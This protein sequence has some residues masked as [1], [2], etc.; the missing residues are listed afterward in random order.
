MNTLL[1]LCFIIMGSGFAILCWRQISIGTRSLLLGVHCFFLHPIFVAIGWWRLYG[2]PFDPRLWVAFIVHDW[3]YFGKENMDGPEGELHPHV[4]ANIMRFLFDWNWSLMLHRGGTDSNGSWSSGNTVFSIRTKGSPHLV[5]V[6]KYFGKQYYTWYD[7]TLFHSHYLA[8]LR[9]MKYSKLCCADKLATAYMPTWF[10]LLQANLSGEVHEYMH[11]KGA[12]TAAM[13]RNQW[14]WAR[15]MQAYCRA[16]AMEHRDC[17]PDHW[18][19]TVRDHAR[20]W[21][22]TQC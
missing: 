18:T 17:K 9:S 10:Y 21:E 7:F 16:W 5:D 19:G 22:A 11:G 13:E 2:F 6:C 3:G 20:Q 12:R 4:G 1:N 15:D 8:K 14:Q